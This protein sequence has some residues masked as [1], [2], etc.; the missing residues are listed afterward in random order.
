M[1]LGEKTPLE[2]L[3]SRV[4]LGRREQEP[5]VG[6]ELLERLKRAAGFVV[7]ETWAI[8]AFPRLD[9]FVEPRIDRM[10]REN[11]DGRVCSLQVTFMEHCAHEA[12][13]LSH[14]IVP[15]HILLRPTRELPRPLQIFRLGTTLVQ[16]HSANVG[17]VV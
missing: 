5:Q 10:F 2:L 12:N 8:D 3:K 11:V 6:H 9:A 17:R 4:R 14:K 1:E 13:H 7:T 16:V 15:I